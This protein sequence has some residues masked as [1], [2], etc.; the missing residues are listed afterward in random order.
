[1]P[2]YDGVNGVARTTKKAYDGVNGVSR[3]TKKAYT[4]VNGVART[5]Y[6]GYGDPVTITVKMENNSDSRE[7]G[8]LS[9]MDIVGGEAYYVGEF[10][11]GTSVIRT[12]AGRIVRF[13]SNYDSRAATGM[14]DDLCQLT[15]E[16]LYMPDQGRY[17]STY[18][19]GAD[20]IEGIELELVHN[21]TVTVGAFYY[22]NAYVN[23]TISSDV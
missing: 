3:T 16:R 17:V 8:E 14:E 1:M 2:H 6:E 18:Y 21:I 10:D 5:Y 20:A 12:N 13:Y 4:G 23:L 19:T 22:D 7:V 9:F 15:L 11:N